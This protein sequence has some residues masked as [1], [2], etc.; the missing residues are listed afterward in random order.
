M[1][2]Y[3]YCENLSQSYSFKCYSILKLDLQNAWQYQIDKS[4]I[5]KLQAYYWFYLSDKASFICPFIFLYFLYNDNVNLFE[6]I[7]SIEMKVLPLLNIC[8]KNSKN[9]HLSFSTY[10][11]ALHRAIEMYGKKSFHLMLKSVFLRYLSEY[12]Y[13][14]TFLSSYFIILLLLMKKKK[15]EWR[16]HN[17][18]MQ[19]FIYSTTLLML[20]WAVNCI[21]I[22]GGIH[23]LI[24]RLLLLIQNFVILSRSRQQ[25]SSWDYVYYKFKTEK[26]FI[27]IIIPIPL[28]YYFL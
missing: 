23:I 5:I 14:K 25:E 16:K 22:N 19:F 24:T 8:Y 28:L 6:Q 13:M 1:K 27:L 11:T 15:K 18:P 4:I 3:W 26:I 2:R 20:Q 12:N 17:V 21:D 7:N 9:F 10:V